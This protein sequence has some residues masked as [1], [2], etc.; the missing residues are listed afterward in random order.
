MTVSTEKQPLNGVDT[1]TLFATL[2]AVKGQHEIAKFQFRASNS[3]V[4]GTHSRSQFSGFYG[5]DAGDGAPARHR[6]RVRPPGRARRARTTRRRRWSTCSTPSQPASPRASPTS[7]PPAASSCTASRSTVEGDID[8]LGILGLSDDTVRNGYEQIQVTFHIEGDADDE[9]L[10]GLVEQSRRR[11][12]VY[13]A[14]TNPH[15]RRHRRRRPLID[16][17]IA[18]PGRATRPGC[19]FPASPTHDRRTRGTQ[20]PTIDTVVIGAGHAGLACQPAAHRGR[21]STTSS[22]TAAGWPSAGAPSA[23]T[24]CTCS[25]RLDDAPPRL[26]VRRHRPRRLP[27]GRRSSS[28]TWRGTPPRSARPWSGGTTCVEV[29][30]SGRRRATAS[31]PTRAPGAPDTSSSR[32]GPHGRPRPAGR[33]RPRER[34]AARPAPTATPARLP[35]R[36][37]GR[38]R[39]VLG[40]ADRRRAG[41]VGPRGRPGRRA[42]HPHAAPLPRHG[43]LLVARGH[44]PAGPHHRRRCPTRGPPAGSRR[45]SWS[46]HDSDPRGQ[47]LDLAA[48]RPVASAWSGG[49]QVDPRAPSTLRRRP[50]RRPVADAD[51][52]LRAASSTTSTRHANGWA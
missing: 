3:W 16:P 23:G 44:R 6:R 20:M 22:S 34:G 40:G 38:R 29:V 15:A 39:L 37:A 2:D 47:D 12:A 41:P 45:C 50:A 51:R 43:R 10:R 4:S 52:R 48:C 19:D 36:R 17:L 26:A 11:S 30:R 8:L 28:T 24:P 21:A 35:R 1:A 5:A 13:D 33:P 49:S 27:L 42:A 18:Q 32:P 9:T 7:P 14:L 46:A 25:P 31:S